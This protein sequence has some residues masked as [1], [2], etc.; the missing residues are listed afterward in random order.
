MSN[1]S[2]C[3]GKKGSM[4]RLTEIYVGMY[5]FVHT[6]PSTS[7]LLLRVQTGDAEGSKWLELLR[8]LP[9][10]PASSY[11]NTATE[12]A[13]ESQSQSQHLQHIHTSKL[14]LTNGFKVDTLLH[15]KACTVGF[16]MSE[17]P[18][19]L[20]SASCPIFYDSLPGL[21]IRLY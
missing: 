19:W 4:A 3:E 18:G 1:N 5:V 21:F 2:L 9:E 15:P 8:M 16:Q 11:G 10:L 13:V 14:P 6:V 12:L 20:C 7:S 17:I